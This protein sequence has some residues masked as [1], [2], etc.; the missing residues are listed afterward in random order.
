M[1]EGGSYNFAKL[2]GLRGILRGIAVRYSE[3][4]LLLSFEQIE[5]YDE[6]LVRRMVEKVMVYEKKFMMEFKSGVQINIKM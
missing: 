3:I 2:G 5:E 1:G 6:S 4:W